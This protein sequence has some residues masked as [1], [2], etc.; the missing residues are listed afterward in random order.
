MD[1]VGGGVSTGVSVA[2]GGVFTGAI[3]TKAVCKHHKVVA[4]R[5]I[6]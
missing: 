1:I 6:F 5:K 3:G 2:V 4:K